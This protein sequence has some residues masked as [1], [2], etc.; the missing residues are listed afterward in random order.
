MEQAQKAYNVQASAGP[1]YIDVLHCNS[2]YP[3]PVADLNLNCISTLHAEFPDSNIGYSGHEYGLI[4]TIATIA[5]GAN[6]IE[7]HVTLDKQMWGSDQKC[8][9]EP[10]AMF[11]LARSVKELHEALGLSLI[12]I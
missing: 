9:L 7:R 5:L 8:S 6:I 1:K 3:A 11:K 4:T 10:H 12:H 2:S